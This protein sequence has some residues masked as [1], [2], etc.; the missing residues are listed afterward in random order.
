M[1]ADSVALNKTKVTG[2]YI[3]MKSAAASQ[4]LVM[5]L[6]QNGQN[7]GTI[8]VCRSRPELPDRGAYSPPRR[9]QQTEEGAGRYRPLSHTRLSAE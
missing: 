5:D 1:A 2:A 4:D 8:G 6:Q 9:P 7:I 3:G